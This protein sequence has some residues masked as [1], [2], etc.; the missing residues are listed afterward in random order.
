MSDA[1][2]M[3]WKGNL[4]VLPFFSLCGMTIEHTF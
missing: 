4:E 1:V 2:G 3:F